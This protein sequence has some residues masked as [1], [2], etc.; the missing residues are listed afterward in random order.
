M[1]YKNFKKTE[2]IEELGSELRKVR[3]A[4]NETLTITAEIME[5]NGFHLSGTMLGR[6]ETG[7]RRIDDPLFE[8][9]C[10]HFK[11]DPSTLVVN[12]CLAHAASVSADD[13][14]LEKEE[15]YKSFSSLSKQH[16]SEIKTM[17]RLFAYMDK[18]KELDLQ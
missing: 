8:A 4:H 12:A 2:F 6:I 11:V 14:A 17:L 16:Q 3:L 5:S 18:F 10:E 9:L 7:E 13:S 1:A 15:L